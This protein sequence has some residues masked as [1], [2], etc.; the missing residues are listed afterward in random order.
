MLG[1]EELHPAR[2]RLNGDGVAGERLHEGAV[3]QPFAQDFPSGDKLAGLQ[4]SVDLAPG[5]SQSAGGQEDRAD[6]L[7]LAPREFEKALALAGLGEQH[8]YLHDI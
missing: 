4:V 6:G 5:P 7:G 8:F 2:D 3:E 1:E